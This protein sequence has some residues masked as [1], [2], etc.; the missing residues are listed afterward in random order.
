ML[1]LL[2]E[3]IDRI[4]DKI[5]WADVLS[6]VGRALFFRF[7]CDRHIVKSHRS[8]APHAGHLN[9]CFDN[10]QNAYDTCRWL[11]DT[12]NGDFLPLSDKGSRK[13]FDKIGE[14]STTVF[15]HL[16]GILCGDEP[17]G[18][19]EYQKRLPIKWSDFNFAH[20]PVAC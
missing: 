20:I 19:D 6:L 18:T 2:N 11:D 17:V 8:I 9:E 7:L 14:R 12:F 13:F 16:K 3:G 15:S 5:G 10:A 4:A 1:N